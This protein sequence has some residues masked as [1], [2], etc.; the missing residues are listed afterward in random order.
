MYDEA[1]EQWQSAAPLPQPLGD[2]RCTVLNCQGLVC[3][4]ITANYDVLSVCLFRHQEFL[5]ELSKQCYLFD[6]H[7]W[8]AKFSLLTYRREPGMVTYRGVLNHYSSTR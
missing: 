4:G 7:T 1:S 3:G 8:T 6:D 5:Q 2:H